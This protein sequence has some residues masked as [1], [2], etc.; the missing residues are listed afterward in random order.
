MSR[1]RAVFLLSLILAALV[2]FGIGWMLRDRS[3]ASLE[4]RARTSV[5]HVRDAFRSLTR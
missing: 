4:A 5:Q 2:G 3:E 1:D